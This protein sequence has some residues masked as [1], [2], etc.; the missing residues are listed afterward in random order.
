M[1]VW[2][3]TRFFSPFLLLFLFL[4]PSFF[5]PSFLLSCTHGTPA[6]FFSFF[7]ILFFPF[8][9]DL[10]SPSSPSSAFTPVPT[11]SSS[12]GVGGRIEGAADLDIAGLE[13]SQNTVANPE[14]STEHL[15]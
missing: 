6:N 5:T 9:S 2:R 11:S 4:F 8:F 10:T 15:H 14:A 7:L 1:H 12:T 3:M 13:I